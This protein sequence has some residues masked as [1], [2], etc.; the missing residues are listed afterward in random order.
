[1]RRRS[2]SR[3]AAIVVAVASAV[4][5]AVL[6]V[7]AAW[8]AFPVAEAEAFE[9]A[10]NA[11]GR[12]NPWPSVAAD[13]SGNYAVAWTR[14]DGNQDVVLARRFDRQGEPL[15]AAFQ[16]N[17]TTAGKLAWPA[18]AMNARGDFAVA[19]LSATAGGPADVRAQRLA[20]DG[21]KIG[22]EVA[23]NASPND[24]G[25][26]PV[27]GI[28]GE[29]GF[30]VTWEGRSSLLLRR[31]DREGAPLGPAMAPVGLDVPGSPRPQ[32]IGTL[33]LAMQP[34]GSFLF[35]WVAA[36][37]QHYS[38]AI[39]G[40][41]F[42]PD[43]KALG[44]D[45]QINHSV[46]IRGEVRPAAVAMADGG[47]VVAWDL[48]PVNSIQP[49]EVRARRFDAEGRPLTSELQV[50]PHDGRTHFQPAIAAGGR[51]CFL[52]AWRACAQSDCRVSAR[53]YNPVDTPAPG[54]S[55]IAVGDPINIA[56]VTGSLQGF[57]VFFEAAAT[58]AAQRLYGWRFD[59]PHR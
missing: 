40:R 25:G 6:G 55:T 27:I 24:R 17:T 58:T 33:G 37:L 22:P 31:F 54:A 48:C 19:W 32:P 9:I 56:W 23:V 30:A 18:V 21:T 44:G 8:A 43:G 15:G 1:M 35:F 28:D 2:G 51:G 20:R 57:L 4:L 12:I 13:D 5:A 50:S 39:F 59:F 34:D 38:A 11:D 47:F 46:L 26:A 10:L 53:A 3:L 7:P 42:G 14:S 16:V 41:R 29:G 52:V 49:C 45:F 36:D